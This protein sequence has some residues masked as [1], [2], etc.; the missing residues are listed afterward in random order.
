MHPYSPSV[1]WVLVK[2]QGPDLLVGCAVCGEKVAMAPEDVDAFA[3]EHVEHEA[4]EG[5]L[6]LGDA[7]AAVAKPIA[8]LLGRKPACSP[9][10]ARRRAMNAIVMRRFW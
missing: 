10:E 3:A 2:P 6:R 4:P 1:P 9:C 5:S 7:M 8:R